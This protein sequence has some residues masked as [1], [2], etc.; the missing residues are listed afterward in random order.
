MSV[1]QMRP[2]FT[3]RATQTTPE[4]IQCF[5]KRVTDNSLGYDCQ[6]TTHH[7][8]VSLQ[9]SQRHFWSPWM[10]LEIRETGEGS[11]IFGRFSPHPSIWTAIMFSY[12]AIATICFFA[13]MFGI[14]QQLAGQSPWAY[15]VIPIGLIIAAVLWLASK[16]GQR[17]AVDEMQQMRSIV[18]SC[19]VKE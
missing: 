9:P 15:V 11:E 19:V 13:I 6:F 8:I 3:L 2:T 4:F 7:V 14:S 12:L 5:R 17:L 10:N 1:A 18:E 16:A